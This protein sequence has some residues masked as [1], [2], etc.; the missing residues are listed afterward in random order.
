V[1]QGR[2]VLIV[3]PAR[4]EQ[5][6]IADVIA[7]MRSDVGCQEALIVVA[8]DD[9]QDDTVAIVTRIGQADPRVRVLETG[10][11]LGV[12]A[13]I[14]RAV[15]AFGAGR[16]WLVRVDAHADYPPNYASRLVAKAQEMDASCV[17]TP[18]VTCGETCFEV[19]VAAASNSVLGTGGAAHRLARGAGWVDHGHHALMRLDVFMAVGGYDASFIANEDADLDARI[20]KIGGRIWLADDLS[21]DYFPRRSTPALFRQYFRYGQGRAMTV[22]RHGGRRKLRQM[23]PLLIAPMVGLAALI[24]TALMTDRFLERQSMCFTQRPSPFGPVNS[25]GAWYNSAVRPRVPAGAWL[26]GALSRLRHH[27]AAAERTLFGR[28]RATRRW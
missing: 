17:V 3:I 23:L 25:Q 14:N 27:S 9:S 6:H 24:P 7:A 28:L 11:K 16:N 21:L 22:A 15:E 2:D 12:C 5:A 26:C 1:N 8:D 20:S 19:A 10:R 13:A 18:M 4:D